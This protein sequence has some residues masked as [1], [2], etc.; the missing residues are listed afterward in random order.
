[1]AGLA[2]F[3]VA[4]FSGSTW[5][6]VR[7]AQLRSTNPHRAVVH[8][9][10]VHPHIRYQDSSVAYKLPWTAGYSGQMIQGNGQGDHSC[11]GQQCYAYDFGMPINTPVR[12]AA[13]G[14]VASVRSGFLNSNC[15][16]G[17]PNDTNSVTLRHADGTATAYIHLTSPS[18]SQYQVVGQGQVIGYSGET[19]YSNCTPHLHFQ[20]QAWGIWFTQSMPV[21]FSEAPGQILQRYS[22]YRSQNSQTTT[23]PPLGGINFWN[24]CVDELRYSGETTVANDA[25][26]YRCTD[27][28]GGTHA[29]SVD[30]A[31][32]WQY[33]RNDVVARFWNFYSTTSWQCFGTAGDLGPINFPLYCHAQQAAGWT[34]LSNNAYGAA[35]W[36]GHGVSTFAMNTDQVCQWQYDQDA[37]AAR[38]VNF[39]SPTGWECFVTKR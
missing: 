14:V 4:V 27:S 12:A 15:P 38:V 13:A 23:A 9:F 3:V 29:F 33:N 35:C 34:I 7:G 37:A 25:Y 20:R 8:M 39:N 1:M 2:A 30:S 19:G 16:Q 22:W 26:G 28:S 18:V 31:C 6:S 17:V 36:H 10:G 11:P 32:R 21:Y 24:Y 5:S